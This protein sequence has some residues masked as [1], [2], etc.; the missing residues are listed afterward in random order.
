MTTDGPQ[1]LATQLRPIFKKHG[2][3]RAVLFGSLARG[4]ASRH[5]DLDLIVVKETDARFLDRYDEILRDITEAVSGYDVD[6]LI[7]TPQELARM[8]QRPWIATALKEGRTIYE[9]EQE[10]PPG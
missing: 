9:S 8:A 5:S 10:P 2:V 6:L 7:Y 4:E 3:L 1:R